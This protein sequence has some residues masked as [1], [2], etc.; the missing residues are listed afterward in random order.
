MKQDL[1]HAGLPAGD[2][3]AR[4]VFEER[5]A[6]LVGDFFGRELALGPADGANLGHRENAGR[7]FADQRAIGLAIDD[8]ARG[9]SSLYIS[10]AG[11]RGETDNVSD[12]I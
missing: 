5:V 6:D 1:Q 10:R 8:V 2:L 4:Q 3:R 9:K 12:G 7:D 11:E